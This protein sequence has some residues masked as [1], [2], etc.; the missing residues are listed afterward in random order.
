MGIL[1]SIRERIGNV[2]AAVIGAVVLLGCGLLFLVVLAPKQKQQA[3]RIEALPLMDASS[4]AFSASA[5][6]ILITGYIH[7]QPIPGA[8]QYIAYELDEW[9]VTPADS[10]DPNDEPSG[11]WKEIERLVPQLDLDVDGQ[12]VIIQS[13]NDAYMN[14]PLHEE[15]EGSGAYLSA[16]YGSTNLS[17]GSLRYRGFY[18]GDLTTVWG[19]K[20]SIEGVIP[21]E[22]FAGDRV[23]F[24]ESQHA[25][26]KGLMIAG[27]S[28]LVCSP[29]VLVGGILSAL[30][31]RRRRRGL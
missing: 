15:V 17:D 7:G 9:D 5:E 31:G 11:S 26:A 22:L 23:T 12:R 21:K 13:N 16:D 25:T 3:I 2:I 6:D 24:I 20:A 19:Q 18:D 27:I 14:G 10:D 28:M 8:G 4:V 30:F 1:A 29:V